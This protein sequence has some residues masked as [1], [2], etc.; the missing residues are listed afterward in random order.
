M[1][2]S[3]ARTRMPTAHARAHAPARPP[4]LGGDALPPPASARADASLLPKGQVTRLV[5]TVSLAFDLEEASAR[6]GLARLRVLPADT[7]CYLSNMAVDPRLRRAGVARAMLV[8]CGAAARRAGRREVYLHVREADAAA[9]ALYSG[10]GFL[11]VEREVGGGGGGLL[12]FG[13]GG[14]GARRARIL[15]RAAA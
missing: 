7:A 10:A 14:G 9:R 3:G 11:E 12:G 5:G 4:R 1:G 13:V 2:A 6:D 15:M 8:A